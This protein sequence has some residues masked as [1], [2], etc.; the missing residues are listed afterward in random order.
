M[1]IVNIRPA[2]GGWSGFISFKKYEKEPYKMEGNVQSVIQSCLK[3]KASLH[4]HQGK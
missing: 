4:G 2:A 1:I 3:G